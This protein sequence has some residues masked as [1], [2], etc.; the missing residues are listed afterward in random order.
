MPKGVSGAGMPKGVSGAGMPKGVSGAGMP[1]RG[2]PHPPDAGASSPSCCP[3]SALGCV[4]PRQ[5]M[6]ER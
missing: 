5:A 1:R 4:F 2:N 6:S 3:S